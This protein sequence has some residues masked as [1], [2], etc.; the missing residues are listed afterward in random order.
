MIEEN[1]DKSGKIYIVSTPIGN[2]DDFTVRALNSLKRCDFV[3]CEE[4]K[5][6]AITLKNI[7]LTKELVPLNEHNEVETTR[8][9]IDRI[10]KGEKACLISDDGTPLIADPGNHFIKVALDEGLD[11]EVVPGVT[12]ILTALVRSGFATHEFVFAGFPGRKT[13]DRFS[14]IRRLS[15]ESRTVILLETPY[16]LISLLETMFKI[17]PNRRAYIGMNLTFPYE[18]HHYGTFEQLYEKFKDY[19]LK[20]EFVVCFEGSEF[21]RIQREEGRSERPNFQRPDYSK[22]DDQGSGYQSRRKY[23]GDDRRKFGDGDRPKFGGDDRRKFG[24]GD[25]P[26]FGGDD[27]RKFGDGDRPKFGGDDRRKF[28]SDDKPNY[29]GGEKKKYGNNPKRKFGSGGPSRFKKRK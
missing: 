8:E 5:I 18:T 11:I 29:G 15:K 4:I 22:K 27:R 17:I 7:N 20:S 16:R 28:E 25:R 14:D 23:E 3:I 21:N 6:G 24:D 19:D 1:K 12:S 9:I 13:E 26:K 10:K 2:K